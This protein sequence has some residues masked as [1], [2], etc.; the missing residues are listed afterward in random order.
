MNVRNAHPSSEELAAFILGQ[1]SEGAAAVLGEHLAGCADCR[2]L[3]GTVRDGSGGL[4][5][6]CTCPEGDATLGRAP[7]DEWATLGNPIPSPPSDELAPELAHHPKYWVVK[8]LGAGGMGVVYKARHLLMERAVALKVICRDLTEERAAVERFRRE[9]KAAAQL[10]HPNI[11]TAYDADQAGEAHFLVMEFVEGTSLDRVLAEEGLLPVARACDYIRQAALGLQHAHE[12]GMIHRDIKPHNLMRTPNGII[13]IL[14]FGLARF[15]RESALAGPTIAKVA[16]DDAL[17][18]LGSLMGTPDYIAPEQAV[19]AHAADARSDLYSLGCTFYFLLSGNAPFAHATGLDKISAHLQKTPEP[20]PRLREAPPGLAAVLDR[21][22]AK[23]P[24]RRYQTAREVADALEPFTHPAPSP[25]AAEAAESPDQGPPAARGRPPRRRGVV[26][27][28]LGG[29]ALL[30]GMLLLAHS[31]SEAAGDYLETI[32][33]VCWV[34]GGTLLLCQFLL[35]LL[36]LGHHHEI[37]SDGGHFDHGHDAGTHHDTSHEGGETGLSWFVGLLT[38]RTL[39]AALLFFGLAG[40]A[41]A[42]EV[43]P[44]PSLIVA[45][46]AAAGALFLVAAI[47]KSL[48]RLKSDGAVRIDRA[49][50]STGTVYLSIPAH[51]SGLGKVL[52]NVQNRTVEYQA[53]TAHQALPTGTPVVVQAVINSDTVEVT[54]ATPSERKRYA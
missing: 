20:L 16:G 13:K 12:K 36:G 1:L 29:A 10:Q 15:A 49:V 4:A 17:T 44:Q 46:A 34:V 48:Y 43:G 8:V 47:M 33:D 31:D 23:D 39:V 40:R 50:G 27:G 37:G 45:L 5:C 9:V 26:L 6:D 38:F 35:S 2:R 21:M 3:L 53:M 24:A 42:P 30:G 14:D 41:A 32:Y 11:V 19:N 25:V 51:K 52:L 22:L 28:G 18:E 7:S 54:V